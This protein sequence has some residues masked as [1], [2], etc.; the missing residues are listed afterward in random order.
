MRERRVLAVIGQIRVFLRANPNAC[1]DIDGLRLRWL[2]AELFAPDRELVATAIER[3]VR[4][5]ALRAERIG[6]RT[7]YRAGN[8]P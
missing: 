3:M 4:A 6:D 1:D 7:I 8:A 2:D 5:R